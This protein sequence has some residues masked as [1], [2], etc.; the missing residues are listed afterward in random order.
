MTDLKAVVFAGQD[1]ESKTQ[2]MKGQQTHQPGFR[3]VNL[4]TRSHDYY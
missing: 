1:G 2:D 4:Q 3:P